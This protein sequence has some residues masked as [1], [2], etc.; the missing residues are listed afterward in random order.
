MTV[1][2]GRAHGGAG[3]PSLLL[4]IAVVTAVAA[5]VF[6]SKS[7]DGK[8]ASDPATTE[9]AQ[10]AKKTPA[11]EPDTRWYTDN[12]GASAFEIST[13]EQL[14]GLARL[15]NDG[16]NSADFSGRTITLTADVNISAYGKNSTFNGGKGWEPIGRRAGDAELPFRGTFNGNNKNIIG[17]YINN[18]SLGQAGLFGL[19][20]KGAVK[21]LGV[22][23]V[24]IAGTNDVGGVAGI[25]NGAA[26]S[27]CYTTGSVGGDARVGGIVGSLIGGGTVSGSFSITSVTGN[28]DIGGLA[29]LIDRGTVSDC[30]A[31]NSGVAPG[32]TSAKDVGR[33]AGRGKTPTFKNNVGFAAM[34][35]SANE[36][37]WA[38][39]GHT[40]IGLDITADKIELDGTVGNRFLAKNGWVIENGRLPGFGAPTDMPGHL[41]VVISD[42]AWYESNP[43]SETFKIST[44]EQIAGLA[45]L[46]NDGN[47]DFE[48]RTIELAADVDLAK[49]GK[50]AKFN[51]GKGWIP[52]GREDK[53]FNGTF[54]G[55]GKRV[56]GLYINDDT[57]SYA[58][59]F[60][61]VRTGTVKKVGVDANITAK[62]NVGGV[63][64]GIVSGANLDACNSA[65][66][67][68]GNNNVGGVLGVGLADNAGASNTCLGGAEN[69]FSTCAVTGKDN[70]GG[71]VGS[72]YAHNS[73]STGKVSGKDNVGGVLGY[74]NSVTNGYATGAVSGDNYI[75]GVLGSGNNAGCGSSV[76]N[77]YA[78]GAVSGKEHVGGLAGMVVSGEVSY[79]FSTGAV[80]GIDFVG[81]LIGTLN[82]NTV[83][84]NVVTASVAHSAAL[85]PTVNGRG[86]NAGRVVGNADL[87]SSN[88]TLSDN[89]AYDGLTNRTGS[90][91]WPARSADA[92][93]GEDITAE[94]I[95]LDASLGSRFKNGNV[96]KVEDGSLPGLTGKPVAMPAHIK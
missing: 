85:N 4:K 48:G 27:Q 66:T 3:K 42:I 37:K 1:I 32:V 86:G 15:V 28:S 54:D 46:V 57:R 38:N 29:G 89:V 34:K 77:S 70:V 67:V 96:W 8:S 78:T 44:A 11:P 80:T 5:S 73:Y 56:R 55:G 87:N 41:S 75:G 72:G 16:A 18:A 71:V 22:L 33:V 52:I 7:S 92:K 90:A 30:A 17:L 45:Q 53:P 47:S 65:G 21:S 14:A 93:D 43:T 35:N 94:E 79:S 24:T 81:G 26:V 39:R 88:I 74:G 19:I 60:G 68:K 83:K 31:L 76:A 10:E 40:N 49:Y 69:S 58:G 91:D 64:G 12:P 20:E 61:Y 9:V 62:D 59:L 6:C 13:P 23:G 50:G 84:G 82:F 25:V 95:S 51:G 36:T 2:A 63:V